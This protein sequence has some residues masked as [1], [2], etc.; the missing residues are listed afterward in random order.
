MTTFPFSAD[1][2][3]ILIN[4]LEVISHNSST[5]SNLSDISILDDLLLKNQRIRSQEKPVIV[6]CRSALPISQ[7]VPGSQINLEEPASIN[8]TNV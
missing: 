2:S 5:S 1:S 3:M 7:D 8:K 6:P 4:D